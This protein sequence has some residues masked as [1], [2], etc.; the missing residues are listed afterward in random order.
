MNLALSA[1]RERPSMLVKSMQPEPTRA[2]TD[3]F[4]GWKAS[5]GL[6]L[7]SATLL[8]AGFFPLN[9]GCCCWFALVP[10]LF[11]TQK[12]RPWRRSIWS[13]WLG[14][15]AF[16]LVAY[17]WIRIASLPMYATW[18]GLALMM[19]CQF[20]LFVWLVRRLVHTLGLPLAI[21]APTIWTALEFL[22]AIIGIGFAWY[23]LGHTQ[24]E[25]LSLI[26]F[27]D[28]TG[29]YGVSF[30]LMLAN[31][32]LFELIVC[33]KE[34]GWRRVPASLPLTLLSVAAAL[35]YGHWR[36]AQADFKP[37]PRLAIIQ[38]NLE[39]DIRNNPNQGEETNRHYLL[40][41]D[42][43]A[44]LKPDLIICPET[45][46]EFWYDV[47]EPTAP[48]ER[49]NPEW[50]ARADLARKFREEFSRRFGTEFLFGLVMSRLT[51]HGVLKYNSAVHVGKNAEE[52]EWC[53]KMYCL[54]FGEYIPLKNSLPFL[55][56]LSPY[57]FEY[58]T[59]CG[60][61]MTLFEVQG[62]RAAVLICYEDTVPH[63]APQYMQGEV[64][65]DFFINLSNDGWFKG[66]E[67]HEQHLATAR[68]RCI[69][70]RRA[71][72]R[73]VNMGVSCVI[74][75]NGAV[76]ALPPGA[77]TLSQA[78]A[79]P[80]VIDATVPIDSR[81]SFYVRAGDWL[82]ISGWL[83]IF[84]LMPAALMKVRQEERRGV[85]AAADSI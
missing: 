44:A 48:P 80:A 79:I 41:A 26:Q 15:L 5:C 83:L 17:Q 46:L 18:I 19:S 33:R 69:E 50:R 34:T 57:D 76:V 25:F 8:W 53:A 37:G 65:P 27:S 6:A 30:L 68:F 11:L 62:R 14:G 9:L 47:I 43:A 59:E 7:A 73:S 71:M 22:R 16:C 78:K 54:P 1:R 28:L 72:A 12:E 42:R 40:L 56:A 55:K 13:A 20:P 45:A 82:P 75:G 21:A 77:K 52:K 32:A 23:Y 64:K 51:N 31:V 29:A 67:E 63:L 4:L 10:L 66:W 49:I 58:S 39:Q 85:A 74:D 3:A 70:C 60:E 2:V 38:G 35:T 81:G 24:H 84:G 36:M 61:R